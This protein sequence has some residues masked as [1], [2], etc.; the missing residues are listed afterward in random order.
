[1]QHN[2]GTPIPERDRARI[3]E[4]LVGT[5]ETSSSIVSTNMGLGLYIVRQVVQAHGGTI[6][7]ESSEATGTS[8]TAKLPRF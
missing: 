3:F 2:D 4:P 1:M 5:T 8:F 6:D 7:V